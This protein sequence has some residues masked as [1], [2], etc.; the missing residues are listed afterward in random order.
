MFFSGMFKGGSASVGERQDWTNWVS[1][2]SG[3]KT[4]AGIMV[5]TKTALANSALRACVTLLAESVA[6]LP[7]ELYRRDANG[8]REKAIDHPLY[9]VLRYQPNK[10]DTCFEY[11]EQN[12]GALGLEG[13]AHAYI[14][15][16]NDGYVK[17]LWPI[18][19]KVQ[20]LK[21]K[22]AMPYYDI[23]GI[24]GIL[25]SRFVHHVKAFSL[26]GYVGLSPLQTSADVIGLGL[27]TEEHAAQVFSRGTTMSGVIE[28]AV[29]TPKIKDQEGVDRLLNKFK[30]RHSGRDNAFS[31]ALLQEG[32]T[33]KQ[34]SMDNEKAQLIDSRNFSVTDICRL[35]KVPPHMV[36]QLDKATNNNIEHQGL[37]FVAYTLLPW[38]KRHEAA[39]MR[40]FLLP[41]ERKELYIEYN[42]SSLMRADQKSRYESYALGRQ[43]GFLSVNDIRRLENL[44]PI[45][46]G[47][48]YLTPMN[49]VD[50]KGVELLSGATPQ[51]VKEIEEIL[52][53]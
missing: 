17:S 36:Q 18:T 6:Q 8:G 5:N 27:A 14:E 13:N 28:S 41:D 43:W 2:I 25:S 33:Y 38:I 11:Q 48:I 42:V 15:R 47:D 3:G 4:K 10:K 20:V 12:Q 37:Q 7:C 29:E 21:G 9:D 51:Q 32:R 19:S 50:S 53:R 26:D 44:P 45:P 39:A 1:S 34:L 46:G 24:D 40:D 16:S 52:E 49:M 35:Y 22:D 31:V 30:D 23:Q